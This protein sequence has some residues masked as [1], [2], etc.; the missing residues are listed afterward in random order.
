[1][2][3]T[4]TSLK[5]TFPK[6]KSG[7]TRSAFWRFLSYSISFFTCC[8]RPTNKPLPGTLLLMTCSPTS[9]PTKPY[10]FP[11]AVSPIWSTHCAGAAVA[12]SLSLFRSLPKQHPPQ[13]GTPWLPSLKSHPP[14]SC[15]S[16]SLSLLSIAPWH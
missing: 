16:P 14:E 5:Q 15:H 8:P 11:S 3:Y 9:P 1:M 12:H 4:H 2:L 13:K 6:T 7:T 10:L